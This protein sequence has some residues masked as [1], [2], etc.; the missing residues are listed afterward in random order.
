MTAQIH[1]Q[2]RTEARSGVYLIRASGG[3]RCTAFDEIPH[4][5]YVGATTLASR[6]TPLRGST[7]V[8]QVKKDGRL[9]ALAKVRL[10]V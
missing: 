5:C 2:S 9:P 1:R 8:I 3:R 6:Q 7:L 10:V 4:F